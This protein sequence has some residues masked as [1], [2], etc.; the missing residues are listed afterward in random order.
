M[1]GW[2][3]GYLTGPAPMLRVM[4]VIQEQMASCVNA[5]TQRAAI[6]IRGPQDCVETMRQAYQRRRD[7]VVERLRRSPACAVPCRTAPTPF[8][9]CAG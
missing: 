1:T 9:T 2:R 5:A 3:I 6:A 4:A 7:L 8:P